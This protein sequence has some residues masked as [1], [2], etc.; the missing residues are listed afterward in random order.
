MKVA[1]LSWTAFRLPLRSPFQTAG[2]E[3]SHREGLILQLTTDD[4]TVG[5]GEATPYIS[6]PEG[7]LQK[8]TNA[9]AEVAPRLLGIEVERLRIDAPP[10]ACAIDTAA[11]DALAQA[12]GVSVA[13][14]LCER[15][16]ERVPVNATVATANTAEAAGLAAAAREAG[17]S[18]VKLKVGMAASAEDERGRVAAVRAA[19]GPNIA[20]RIDANGGWQPDQAIATIQA[21]ESFDLELVEQPIASGQLAEMARIRAAVAVAIAADEDVTSVESARRVLAAGAAD[22]LVVKP[23]TCGGIKP[24]REIATL[25]EDAGVAVIVTTT[26]DSGVGTAAA[27]QLAATLPDNGPACGLATGGLFIDDLVAA[28]FS[29]R[30]GWLDAASGP[31]LGVELDEAKLARYGI[32]KGEVA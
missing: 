31:G 24:A 11:C 4:G 17:F 10:L 1:K 8:L 7:A 27:L 18:C 3:V 29:A 12:T 19:L 16:L 2:G 6:A 14:L 5:L 25:A 13:Q 22:A 9:L 28:P 26:I 32:D 23:M 20:L 30:Q 15:P 21:L